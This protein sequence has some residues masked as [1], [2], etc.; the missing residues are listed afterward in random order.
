L[1]APFVIWLFSIVLGQLLSRFALAHIKPKAEVCEF[2]SSG[3]ALILQG[4]TAKKALAASVDPMYSCW[5]FSAV[6]G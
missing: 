3:N 6:L 4:V 5:L 2:V 1:E